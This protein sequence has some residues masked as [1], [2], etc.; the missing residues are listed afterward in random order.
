MADE[1]IKVIDMHMHP[2]T[3]K[4][5]KSMGEK[6]NQEM[7]RYLNYSMGGMLK[8]D[9]HQ[10]YDEYMS[11]ERVEVKKM[12]FLGWN[13]GHNYGGVKF[14]NEDLADMVKA[15]PDKI[16]GFA[17]V[18]PQEGIY[19]CI[20]ELEHCV[21]DLGLKG[22]KLHTILQ[23]FYPNDKKM[24]PIYDCCVDLDIPITFHTG[25]EGIGTG[26]P[27]GD[28]V[29][30]KYGNPIYIDDVAADFPKLR[31]IMA[32]PGW[33]WEDIGIAICQ[34]KTNVYMDLSSMRPKFF[35]P[36]TKKYLRIKTFARKALFGTDYPYCTMKEYI[37]DLPL[38]DIKPEYINRIM[39][40]NAAELLRLED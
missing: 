3:E 2:M 25:Y 35:P 11:D 23:D 26:I 20:K 31:I 6:R 32:H 36:S 33:P 14:P 39:Y 21:K 12:V 8:K 4:Y 9:V 17:Q 38:L 34:H 18:N 1:K 22:L 19:N 5:Y 24:Y 28:G 40:E 10:I 15:Y 27:G 7:E 37:D 30:Q 29:R 13:T 16:I